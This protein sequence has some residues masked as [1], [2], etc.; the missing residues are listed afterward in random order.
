MVYDTARGRTVLFGGGTSAPG[1]PYQWSGETWEWAESAWTQVA[2]SGPG[3]RHLTGMAYDT[4][5]KHVLLFGGQE[6]QKAPDAPRPFLSDTWLWNGD[7]WRKIAE[8]GPPPRYGHAMAFDTRAGMA[9]L[10]GGNTEDV[11]HQDMWR[12]DGERWSQVTLTG[13]T[14]GP[15]YGSAM[16]YDAAR[17]RTVLYGGRRGDTSTWEW[18]GTRWTEIK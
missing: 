1:R 7:S 10:Y 11:Q 16:A 5:R 4:K 13:P 9:L 15:R 2:E 12:W 18:D 8:G 14:P 17:D 6:G 3:A